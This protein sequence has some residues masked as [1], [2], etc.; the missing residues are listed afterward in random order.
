MT[1]NAYSFLPWLR[2]G[3]ATRITDDPGTAERA[4]V[5]VTLRVTG[6]ALARGTLVQDVSREVQLYG[7]GDVVGVDPR[8]ISR[9]E[10]RPG[11]TNVE[12]NYLA[13]IEFSDEDFLWRYSPAASGSGTKRLAPWLALIVLSAGPDPGG[14]QAEFGEAAGGGPLPAITVADPADTLPPPEQLG[15]WAHV[16]VNGSLDNPVASDSTVAALAALGEVLR[17]NADNACSRLICPRRL[18]PDTAYE[19]F[20]VP[21]FETGR[22]AGLGLDPGVSPGALYSSWGPPY[23]NRPSAGQLPYYHRWS[24]S[25]GTTGDFEFLVRL[26]QPQRPDPRVGRRDLDVHRSPG[27]GLPGIETPPELGGVLPLGGALKVPELP[28]A[29]V[30]PAENWDNFLDVPPPAPSYPHPFEQALADLV[31]LSDDY[32]ERT[33]SQA[34]A[35]VALAGPAAALAD[36]TATAAGPGSDREDPAGD[37]GAD[38]IITPPLYGRWHALTSRLLTNRDGTPIPAPATHNWLHRLNLDPR[39]RVAAN[40]G[41]Q[42]VRAL[43]EELMA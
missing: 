13:H 16:H 39:F 14:G 25:T 35:A 1:A 5:P 11:V 27:L 21:A 6:D 34:H 37:C 41:A 42:V 38:P 10:P 9:T 4:S 17:T 32:Q 23:P 2:T 7:P 12:P 26:L 8:A 33:P 18:R 29:P 22:L 36:A 40:L 24:F 30:D 28:G 15:A 3:I 19:A 20:L 31:N 43:E